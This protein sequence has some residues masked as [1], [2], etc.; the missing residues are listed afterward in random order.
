VRQV[1][2]Q[3]RELFLAAAGARPRGGSSDLQVS[4]DD[5][6]DTLAT[7]RRTQTADEVT[8]DRDAGPMIPTKD[9]TDCT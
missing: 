5:H 9:R 1:C 2:A 8:L 6:C 4:K 7:S 3:V